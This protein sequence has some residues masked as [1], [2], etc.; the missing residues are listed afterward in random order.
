MRGCLACVIAVV[1]LAGCGRS[2]PAEPGAAETG[3]ASY[4]AHK[5]HGRTTASGE[6]YDET[7]MTAAH[8]ELPFGTRIR[9]TNLENGREAEFRVTDRGPFV[10]GRIVDV[11]YQGAKEL[12]FVREGI[13]RVRLEVLSVPRTGS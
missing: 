12:D 13:V 5:F 10:K 8:K 4:Y 1:L 11:S 6:V 9:V 7:R 3:I 2:R